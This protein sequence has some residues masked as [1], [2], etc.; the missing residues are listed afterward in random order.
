[1]ILSSSSFDFF[2]MVFFFFDTQRKFPLLREEV[3]P[4]PRPSPIRRLDKSLLHENRRYYYRHRH[5]H[6]ELIITVMHSIM[7]MY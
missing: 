5:H 6:H 7:R 4:N 2:V 1:M 3:K